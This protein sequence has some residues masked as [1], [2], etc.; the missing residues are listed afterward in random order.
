MEA[1]T[2]DRHW[3]G[4]YD[5][6]PWD[7]TGRY[8]LAN[9]ASIEGEQPTPGDTI[10]LG[11]I[12]LQDDNRF[13]PLDTTTE[14]SWQQGAMLQWVGPGYDQHVIYNRRSGIRPGAVILNVHT[15]GTRVLDRPIYA[16]SPDGAQGVSLDFHR[17]HHLRRGYGYVSADPAEQ[18][19]F[20]RP[21]DRGIYHADLTTGDSELVLTLA[22]IAAFQPIGVPA[23][24]AQWVNHLQINPSGTRVAFLHRWALAEIPHFATRLMTCNFDGSDL[25][26]L[27]DAGTWST[28]SHYDWRD[29]H[30]LLMWARSRSAD[31]GAFYRFDDRTGA[32][33]PVGEDVMTADGHCSYSPDRQWILNDSYPRE[34]YRTLYLY[35]VADGRR[36][37]LGRFFSPPEMTGDLRC[38]LHPRWN[39]EGKQVCIDS[40]HTGSRRMYILDVTSIVR[41]TA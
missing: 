20:P 5:K 29:E 11:M 21:D 10:D 31:R 38:D 16:V 35:R 37:D 41:Q 8:L 36:F 26:V 18:E 17:L 34:D 28:F 40:A 15:T 39:R 24:K 2:D 14:W 13:I 19:V 1:V 27:G 32:T 12:D 33:E 25:R 3:F 23:D 6:S 22:E 9:R 4:Y 7:A 30:T